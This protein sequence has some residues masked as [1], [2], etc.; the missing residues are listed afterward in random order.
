MREDVKR[1]AD[2][3]LELIFKEQNDMTK[4]DVLSYQTDKYRRLERL[5]ISIKDV[6]KKIE[7]ES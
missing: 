1:D 6:T 7:K 3:L 4:R 2:L 5:K